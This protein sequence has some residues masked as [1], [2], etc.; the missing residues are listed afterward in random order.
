[1]AKPNVFMHS[2]FDFVCMKKITL[3]MSFPTNVFVFPVDS[4]ETV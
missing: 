4:M 1:M 3:T 2:Y